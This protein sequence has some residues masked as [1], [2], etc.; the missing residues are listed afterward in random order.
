MIEEIRQALDRLWKEGYIR[1]RCWGPKDEDNPFSGNNIVIATGNEL[2]LVSETGEVREFFSIKGTSLGRKVRKLLKEKGLILK[3]EKIL[4]MTDYTWFCPVCNKRGET[5]DYGENPQVLANR[6]F[7]Q[8]AEAS[9]ECN[10]RNVQVLNRD[11]VLQ[12][13]ITELVS[14]EKVK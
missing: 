1:G 6:I 8:H 10:S 14:L 7:S 4:T 2:V 13:Q 5:E 11:L 3:E 12:E 9:P